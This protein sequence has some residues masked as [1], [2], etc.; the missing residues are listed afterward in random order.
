MTQPKLVIKTLG[1]QPYEPVWRAM[2]KFT[3]ERDKETPDE[4]WLLEHDPVYTQGQNGKPEHIYNPGEIPVI[5]VDRGG[6]IT[7]HGPGQ[8]I[9]Y[10]LV[11]LRRLS[12]GVRNLVTAIEKATIALLG[13]HNVA[14]S[15]RADAPGVYIEEKKIASLGLRVRR[16]CSYHGLSFNINMDLTPYKGINPCGLD[17]I[18]MTQLVNFTQPYQV[19]DIQ[20]QWIDCF[21]RQLYPSPL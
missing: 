3:N 15:A 5:Q 4:I 10:V 8:L 2:Q 6:Q 1:R 13:E 19:E 21:K 7:Y 14:A 16:G 9:A 17:N 11:D 12:I 18:T 20:H